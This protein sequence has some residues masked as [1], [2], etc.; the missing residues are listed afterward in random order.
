MKIRIRR[1]IGIS[2][3]AVLVVVGV[4]IVI[5]MKKMNTEANKVTVSGFDLTG[6]NDGVYTGECGIDFLCVKVSVAVR[7]QRIEKI[8][9]LEHNG[10]LGGKAE[11]LVDEVL[12]TQSLLDVDI[13]SGATISS[14][15]ILKAIENALSYKRINNHNNY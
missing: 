9:I 11:K 12:K 3:L 6:I 1:I 10:G 15:A 4:S 8:E 14:K 5:T 7:N 13:V 2:L